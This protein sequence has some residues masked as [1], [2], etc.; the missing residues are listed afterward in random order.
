VGP[1]VNVDVES[2]R[3]VSLEKL[4]IVAHAMRPESERKA[5]GGSGVVD[6]VIVGNY[7]A[8]TWPIE[9]Y[10]GRHLLDDIVLHQVIA[11]DLPEPESVRVCACRLIDI[12]VLQCRMSTEFLVESKVLEILYLNST[13]PA[14]IAPLERYPGEY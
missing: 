12:V 14:L 4:E 10:W 1:V 13:H 7:I 8:G 11:I 6:C 5:I 3:D 9:Y 2:G